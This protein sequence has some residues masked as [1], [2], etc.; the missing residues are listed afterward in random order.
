MIKALSISLKEDL[1]FFS[2]YLFRRSINHKITEERGVIVIWVSND[3]DAK[4]VQHYFQQWK[5]GDLTITS[6]VKGYPKT[7]IASSN[8]LKTSPATVFIVAISILTTLLIYIFPGETLLR[9]LTFVD[10]QSPI[11]WQEF[12]LT[13]SDWT[14]NF[15]MH[16]DFLWSTLS[17]GQWWRL[18]TPAFL[19]FSLLH[20][21]F[22]AAM[23]LFFGQ[24]IESRHGTKTF[25][26]LT[27]IFA[28]FSNIVQYFSAY[29]TN[30]FGGLS[31]IIYGFIGFCWIRSKE[32]HD[33]YAVPSGIYVFMVVW[34]ILGYL[35]VLGNIGLGN[36]ANGAHAG[37]FI[38]GMVAGFL[39]SKIKVMG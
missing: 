28:L 8:Y 39:S 16:W 26:V 11:K 31:G 18:I 14:K 36:I 19:H 2:S 9:W 10:P 15:Q 1:S 27:A 17:K 24:R 4:L 30:I 20:I 29:M 3:N 35:G 34:L 32:M 38:A 21:A 25:L 37:G 7:T 6:S 12:Y 23:F 5:K 33:G 13:G 22:N